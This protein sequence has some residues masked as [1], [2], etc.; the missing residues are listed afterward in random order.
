MQAVKTDTTS[1]CY[2]AFT[3]LYDY[4]I[5]ANLSFFAYRSATFQRGEVAT[6]MGYLFHIIEIMQGLSLVFFNMYSYCYVQTLVVNVG[7]VVNSP[8]LAGN[9]GV[10]LGYELY[11][12]Y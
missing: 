4:L 5:G 7:K 12:Y 3:I 8:A 1:Q 9:L 11:S 10:T 6:D 2:E